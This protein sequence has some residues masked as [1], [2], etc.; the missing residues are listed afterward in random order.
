MLGNAIVSN[1][2]SKKNK[3]I[4]EFRGGGTRPTKTINLS[5][6]KMPHVTTLQPMCSAVRNASLCLLWAESQAARR[7]L[8]RFVWRNY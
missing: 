1:V 6:I 2:G 8:G 7:W 5:G 4:N 3:R